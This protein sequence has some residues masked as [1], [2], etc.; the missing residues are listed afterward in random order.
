MDRIL[1]RISRI[2]KRLKTEE[3]ILEEKNQTKNE[4][5]MIIRIPTGIQA[6]AIWLRII[7]GLTVENVAENIGKSPR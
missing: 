5:E 7:E 2:E 1:D 6:K 4:I 3:E